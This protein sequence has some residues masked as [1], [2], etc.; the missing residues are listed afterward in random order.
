MIK[1]GH[2]PVASQ[3]KRPEFT[4]K[5]RLAI[6]SFLLAFLG[7]VSGHSQSPIQR[8]R[9]RRTSLRSSDAA[10]VEGALPPPNLPFFWLYLPE[11][12]SVYLRWR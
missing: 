11:G 8:Q 3:P 4:R 12:R 2:L 10:L 9:R 1:N 5:H 7:N 6:S